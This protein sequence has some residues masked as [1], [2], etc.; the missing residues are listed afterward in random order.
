MWFTQVLKSIYNIQL[1]SNELQLNRE[2]LISSQSKNITRQN[3]I[4]LCMALYE[5]VY[6]Y[7]E[8]IRKSKRPKTR[9]EMHFGICCWAQKNHK[10]KFLFRKDEN[11][12]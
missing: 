1:N 11:L 8:N 4:E 3:V 5:A 7:K 2:T 12:R 6:S 9:K 10:R